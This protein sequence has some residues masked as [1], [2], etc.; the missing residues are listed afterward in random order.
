MERQPDSSPS[1]VSQM[2]Q[3]QANLP[4][5][6][7]LLFSFWKATQLNNIT[8]QGFGGSPGGWDGGEAKTQS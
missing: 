1:T 2:R 5:P 6:K 8:A 4:I 7:K 3:K